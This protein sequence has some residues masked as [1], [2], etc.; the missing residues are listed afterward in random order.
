ML[1]IFAHEK[2]IQGIQIFGDS[3]IVINWMNNAHRCHNKLLTPILEEVAQLKSTFNLI[4]FNHI[5]RERNMEADRCSKEV[6]GVLHPSW[7]IEE[8][9]PNGAYR[10]YHR[11]FMENPQPANL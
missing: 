1:L 4:T 3:M 5:Y 2:E 6:S 11:P 8:S 10:Y 7:E 9:G